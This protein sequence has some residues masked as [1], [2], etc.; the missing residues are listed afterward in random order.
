MNSIISDRFNLVEEWLLESPLIVSYEIVRR[1][2]SHL[3][4]KLRIKV[5]FFDESKAELF[6]YVAISD[7]QIDLL[8]YSFH[9]QDERGRLRYRWD[10][11]PH[12]QEL[13]GSPHHRH[14]ADQSVNGISTVLDIFAVL[15]E[16]E[17][18]IGQKSDSYDSEE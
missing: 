7:S 1:D 8:K 5:S 2:I 4:G 16:I 10:N 3:D 11:A 12:H 6:E 9:W 14:N 15:R 18:R 17:K 13:S